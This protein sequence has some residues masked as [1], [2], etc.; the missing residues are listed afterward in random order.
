MK[1]VLVTGASGLIGTDLINAI[2]TTHDI[3]TF[4]RRF[5]EGFSGIQADIND[6]TALNGAM[7]GIHT[8]VHLAAV[9]PDIDDD[10][11]LT[12]VNVTGTYNL[13][14]LAHK[15]SVKRVV[16][17]SSGAISGGYMQ[18]P[19]IRQIVEGNRNE[20]ENN[21][22]MISELDPPR[23]TGMYA[24]TKLW[25]EALGRYHSETQ[26]ISVICLRLGRVIASDAPEDDLRRSI[27]LSRRD[28]VQ[29]ITKS[30]EAPLALRFECFYVSSNNPNRWRDN[31][32]A[33][34]SIGF[35]PQD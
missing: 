6:R 19:A 28:A 15:N 2:N 8:V 33:K 13:L 16:L 30:I 3:R 11:L 27:H 14:D 18:E 7:N 25:G 9:L 1:S 23:P 32:S 29:A 35:V 5:V 31:E 10:Q 4:S 21:S 12:E 26:G 34:A 17:A 22:V 20:L 24:V